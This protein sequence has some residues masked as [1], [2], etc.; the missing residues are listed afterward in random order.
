MKKNVCKECGKEFDS[1]K[2][3]HCHLKTHDMTMADYYIKHYPRFNKLTSEP[4]P[5]R[6]KDEY[7]SRDFNNYK[8]LNDWCAKSEPAEVK[9]YI[10]DC[11]KKRIKD[12]KLSRGPSHLELT[13]HQMPAINYYI[14]H[15]GSYTAA[16][17][18]AGVEPLFNKRIPKDFMNCDTRG[19]HV[20]IDTREQQPL[21]FD[22]CSEMA[23]NIGDYTARG[24]FYDRT[25]IDRKS[26]ND[27][28][29]TLS[30]ANLDRFKR[31][32]E[33][34]RKTD[35]YLFVAV[36]STL[37][38][39]ESYMRAAKSNKF[40]PHKTNLKFI[41]HNMRE[42]MHEFA[43]CCQF[44]FVDTREDLQNLVPKILFFGRVIWGVDIQ[45]YIDHE[46]A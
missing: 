46:L 33:R 6:N 36:E 17:K 13:I 26:M 41:Y 31:E 32:V 24:Q 30:L 28:I 14:E 22:D 27:F 34:V 39:L 37:E 1:E 44:I 23:L 45:Y 8:Q 35:S 40:G 10:L 20:F 42:I 3:L 7:F 19:L 21:E 38:K 15:F 25:Y 5:F 11:L 4:M 29:G 43:D 2:G 16:C 18:E 12:K 9:P